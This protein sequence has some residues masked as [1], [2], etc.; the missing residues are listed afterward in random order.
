[1]DN[2]ERAIEALE[3][4]ERMELREQMSLD[5]AA[6]AP[7]ADSKTLIAVTQ[8]PIIEERLRDYKAEI[9]AI[10]AEA[11]TMVAT[12]DTIQAVKAKR[13]ELRKQF[14]D[15]DKRRISV[16]NLILEPYDRFNKIYDECV[17]R[18]FSDADAT[19]KFTVD[20]FEGEL[21][22][23]AM[24]KL[25]ENYAEHCQLEGIDWLPFDQALRFSGVK[26][27]MADTKTKTPRKAMDALAEFISKVALGVESVRKMEDSAEIMVEFKKC[28]DAGQA[29][30]IVAER[31]RKIQEA[32]EA[33]NRR[34]EEATR[35]QEMVAKVEAAAPAPAT[36][37]APEPVQPPSTAEETPTYWKKMSFTIYFRD[38]GEYEKALPALRQL[39][40]I[41]VQEGIQYGK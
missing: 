21:K 8:L 36:V 39:K 28:L 3:A 20:A 2:E 15:L 29:A 32:A 5:E 34:K 38:R 33:E 37:A 7:I 19:L 31:K 25:A 6:P 11:K 22:A 24:E 1:M 13:A 16:K 40:E 27:S 4:A 18:P 17:K 14:D 12:P 26:I 35:Q 10:V 23:Q 9:E 41:L 30:G